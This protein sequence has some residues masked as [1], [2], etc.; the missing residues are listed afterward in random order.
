MSAL[1]ETPLGYI[2]SLIPTWLLDHL[3]ISTS[4]AALDIEV[5]LHSQ[6]QE[7]VYS[8]TLWAYSGKISLTLARLVETAILS[9]S[10]DGAV[11]SVSTLFIFA[12]DH[13]GT[14]RQ[15]SF[16]ADVI[17]CRREL[18]TES[19]LARFLNY[20]GSWR[21]PAG[22]MPQ[23][24]LLLEPRERTDVIFTA[25]VM[26]DGEPDSMTTVSLT[27]SINN[28]SARH[29]V[30]TPVTRLFDLTT[31]AVVA[32]KAGVSLVRF[33]SIRVSAGTRSVNFIIDPDI[34]PHSAGQFCICA[35]G[36]HLGYIQYWI[37][38]R[39]RR[40]LSLDSKTAVSRGR[41]IRYAAKA[42]SDWT[43][44]SFPLSEKEFAD[45]AIIPE[46]SRARLAAGIA[47][48][49]MW[50]EFLADIVIEDVKGTSDPGDGEPQTVEISFRPVSTSRSEF[51]T[52]TSAGIF[53]DEYSSQFS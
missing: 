13:D 7:P 31:K 38:S 32:L 18:Q 53:T 44:L 6:S 34:D 46:A 42:D 43:A 51:I 25:S 10:A 28:A 23:V 48:N 39:I 40:S 36:P 26:R 9:D 27:E 4:C 19:I 8:Q 35:H 33:L 16:V 37:I 3:T 49:T 47:A 17:W 24:A 41:R 21:I 52:R 2:P 50:P 45:L 1:I 11:P 30:A 5:R 14:G 15:L 12:D 29:T 22:M 20:S